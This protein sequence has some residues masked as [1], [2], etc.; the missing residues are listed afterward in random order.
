MKRIRTEMWGVTYKGKLC[1]TPSGLYML[2]PFK[3]DAMAYSPTHGV[4]KVTVTI[5]PKE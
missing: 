3:R 4:V 2:Y 1:K 5:N